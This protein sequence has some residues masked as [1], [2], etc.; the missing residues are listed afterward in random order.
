MSRHIDFVWPPGSLERQRRWAEKTATQEPANDNYFLVIEAPDGE[1]AG[2]IDTH[3]CDRRTGTFQY[4]IA[5]RGEY[6]RHGYAREAILLVLRYF[7]DELRYQKV[8]VHVH[9]NNPP[10][11]RLHEQLGFALEGRL[12]RIIYTE[13]QYYDG[14]YFGMTAEEYRAGSGPAYLAQAKGVER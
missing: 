11:I 7:F 6:Q 3:R 12:R 8:T 9:S 1:V 2:S 5:V 10:S 14:L 4:G 13:G